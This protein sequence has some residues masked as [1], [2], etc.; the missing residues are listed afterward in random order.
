VRLFLLVIDLRLVVAV[1]SAVMPTPV[2][3]AMVSTVMPTPV[4]AVVSAVMPTPVSAV[5]S[6]VMAAPMPAVMATPMNAAAVPMH[7]PTVMAGVHRESTGT[8]DVV[9]F[10]ILQSS[11][12]GQIF[13]FY[14]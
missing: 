14:V 7:A 8:D 2:T 11:F 3:A 9:G 6:A 12:D 1:V 13:D 5:V 10:A 4:S